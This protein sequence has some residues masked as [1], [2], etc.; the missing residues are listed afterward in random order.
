MHMEHT[1]QRAR[2]QGTRQS[3]HNAPFTSAPAAVTA[4]SLTSFGQNAEAVE[5]GRAFVA[6][7]ALVEEAVCGGCPSTA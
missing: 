7:G 3:L 1:L 4:F 2:Q 6:G 5:G